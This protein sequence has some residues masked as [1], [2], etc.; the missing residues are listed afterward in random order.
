MAM[1]LAA[2]L[3]KTIDALSCIWWVCRPQRSDLGS[4]LLV[5][6]EAEGVVGTGQGFQQPPVE[7]VPDAKGGDDVLSEVIE[8]DRLDGLR[9]RVEPAAVGESNSVAGAVFHVLG[10]GDIEVSSAQRSRVDWPFPEAV[11]PSVASV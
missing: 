8:V 9:R 1:P 3:S 6:D 7:D 4:E 11:W 10:Q 5:G 2:I